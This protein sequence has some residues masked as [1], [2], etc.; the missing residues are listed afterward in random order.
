MKDFKKNSRAFHQDIQKAMTQ[1]LGGNT[2][3]LL[4]SPNISHFHF[5]YALEV[6]L[7]VKRTLVQKLGDLNSSPNSAANISI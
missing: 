4:E 1:E 3:S 6:A 5:G 7:E 2:S